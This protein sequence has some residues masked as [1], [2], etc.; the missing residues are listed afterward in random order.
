M[1][2]RVVKRASGSLPK[3]RKNS[4]SPRA[5]QPQIISSPTST[6]SSTP[7]VS[8]KT[9]HPTSD[10][11]KS[12]ETSEATPVVAK[13]SSVNSQLMSSPSASTPANPSTPSTPSPSLPSHSTPPPAAPSTPSTTG[14]PS[15]GGGTRVRTKRPIIRKNMAVPEMSPDPWGAGSTQSGAGSGTATTGTGS[16]VPGSPS[17]STSLTPASAVTRNRR[18]TIGGSSPRLEEK[19]QDSTSSLGPTTTASTASPVVSSVATPKTISVVMSPST[20]ESTKFTSTSLDK[21]GTKM[22]R[23]KSNEDVGRSS[24]I[25][26]TSPSNI[27]AKVGIDSTPRKKDADYEE[28]IDRS[29]TARARFSQEEVLLPLPATARTTDAGSYSTAAGEL[30]RVR[31]E[32]S[33]QN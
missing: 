28:S 20:S 24:I 7:P 9:P 6:S 14:T 32:S 5:Q 11:A 22:L 33:Y 13:K 25:R 15:E 26:K 23:S 10:Q 29:M 31:L 3:H 18:V 12:S 27:L 8:S 16:S 2:P 19:T 21:S 17:A 1:S 30:F 4:L